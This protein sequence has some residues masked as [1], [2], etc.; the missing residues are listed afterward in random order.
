MGVG[1]LVIFLLTLV[2]YTPALKNDFVNWDDDKYVYENPKIQSLDVQSLYWMLTS[3]HASNWHPLTWVSHAIDYSL[4]GLNPLGHHLTN[5]TFHALNALLVFLLV[6]RLMLR[7]QE[8]NRTLPQLKDPLSITT[9]SLT[10]A[11]ITALLFGLHPLHVESVV[12]VAE[13]KDLLCSFFLLSSILCYLLYASSISRRPRWI[14]FTACLLLF[15]LALMSKPMAV[16][17]PFILLLLDLY[18]LKRLKPPIHKN[19]SL[20]LEKIP[21]FILSLVSS[22]ITVT[23]Q[24]SG[25]A[26]KGLEEFYLDE[27]LLNAIRSLAF[28]LGKTIIPLRLVPFYPFPPHL[29]WLD[30]Q[31]LLSA[32]LILAITG[33]CLWMARQ[34]KYLFLTVWSYYLITLLP[35]VGIIQ[36]GG[37]AAADRYTYLPSISLFLL[38]GIFVDWSWAKTSLTGLKLELRGLLLVCLCAVAFL[39]SYIT[40]NQIKIWRNSE[41]LWS[42]VIS[43]FPERIPEAY[44]NLGIAYSNKGMLDEA[45]SECKK[46]LTI[47]PNFAKAHN[48]LCAAYIGK[49]MLDEAISEGKKALTINPNFVEAHNNLGAAYIGKGM[50]DE[51]ITVCK[52]A[53]TINPNFAKA[54]TNLGNAYGEKGML[55]EA[56]S[57]GKKALTINP[58]LSG[59]HNNLAVDYYSK[60]NYRLAI[61]HCD[62]AIELGCSVNAKLLELLEPYR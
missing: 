48:N 21:F 10:V 24:Q 53:L 49:G 62:K 13:R 60:G 26:I 5:I 34:G 36:V 29:H 19:L 38:V 28:Y 61:F 42:Y 8:L 22:V 15:I 7:T 44:D 6:I 1:A 54:H 47:N 16:T 9:K 27:R 51:A 40:I 41:I 18:P 23:A 56:I 2:V 43:A 59:V 30:S 37:Q 45:I 32:L 52:K 17:L 46:A 50:L 57:E 25:G 31:Y 14:W 4:W 3:F 35:V 12:W 55:D 11:G 58:N 20:I 39:L 33:S